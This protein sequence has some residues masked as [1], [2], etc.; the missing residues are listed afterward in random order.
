MK[1]IAIG[2]AALAW[3][4][5]TAGSA[6]L[7]GQSRDQQ[8]PEPGKTSLARVLVVNE[9]PN[10]AVPVTWAGAGDGLKVQLAG[11]PSVQSHASRQIWEYRQINLAAGQD[12][13]AALNAAG[14]DGWETTGIALPS[15]GSTLV[16]LKR[17]R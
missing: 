9:G 4:V 14:Q 10:A 2:G 5:L 17:P 7:S 11:T 6:S 16:I 15:S 3:A 12:A 1:R 13:A 8:P